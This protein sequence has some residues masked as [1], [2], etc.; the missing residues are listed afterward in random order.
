MKNNP[1]KKKDKFSEAVL[2]QLLLYWFQNASKRSA[3]Q[4]EELK[5]LFP[6]VTNDAQCVEKCQLAQ[7]FY[8]ADIT[9]GPG[10]AY[11]R[12]IISFSFYAVLNG[13]NYIIFFKA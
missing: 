5:G 7:Y 11:K 1:G 8:V 10:I 2:K 6:D 13:S 9:S 4:I 12:S 3:V